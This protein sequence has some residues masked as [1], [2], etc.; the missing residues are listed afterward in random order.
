MPGLV[1]I[2]LFFADL[3][4]LNLAIQVSYLTRFSGADE[5]NRVYLLIYSSLAWLFLVL[6]SNPYGITKNWTLPKIIKSQIVF[7][8][9]HL[10]VV[11][12]LILFFK[13]SYGFF[14]I[15]TIY[16][17]FVPI[18]FLSKL[19]IFYVRKLKTE[20]VAR[21]YL[22]IGRNELSFELRRYFLVH[23]AERF[24]FVGYIDLSESFVDQVQDFCA[25]NEVHQIFCCAPEVTEQ[26][27][28]RLVNFGLNSLIQVKIVIDAG[29]ISKRAL[30]LDD[31]DHQPVFEVAV[32]PLDETRNQLVK[33]IFDIIFSAAFSL[34]VL[35]WLI[36]IIALLIKLDS[37]GPVFFVQKRNGQKNIPFGCIKFR[38]M[39][40]NNE[41]DTKQATKNDS[42][43]T[44]LGK[45]LRKSSI[46][47]L[48]QFINVITN[49]MSLIGPRPHPIKLNEEFADRINNIMA[50]HYVKPGITGLAQCMGY[51]GETK[52][53]A[54]MENR[55][56]LD[57]YYIENWSFWLDIRIIFLTI[58]SL[59]RGSEKAY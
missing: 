5:A 54:D 38:T 43:I 29:S 52:D 8:L 37:R 20:E 1:R 21:N 30:K 18:F 44:R 12:S 59:L 51:R 7:L 49:D 2:F 6:V 28:S 40:V 57:R 48:P 3:F 27:M 9:I 53:L 42:R 47:E 24:R 35:S 56:R 41:S 34:L 10:M 50:R 26:E 33:R 11:T 45:F 55:V 13:R 22:L 46:D 19:A 32:I 14:Q 15:G 31:N 58:I 17:V 23:P 16:I 39:V 25:T 4:F 36:P